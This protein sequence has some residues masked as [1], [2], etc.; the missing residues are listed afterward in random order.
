MGLFHCFCSCGETYVE[1]GVSKPKYQRLS[2]F[3]AGEAC[4][5]G[6][7]V[8][9]WS[10]KTLIVAQPLEH[11]SCSV[12]LYAPCISV[13][14]RAFLLSPLPGSHVDFPVFAPQYLPTLK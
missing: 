13:P 4:R 10:L 5:L 3:S 8:L 6:H 9:S 1:T 14:F 12:P 2:H 11:L 7:V